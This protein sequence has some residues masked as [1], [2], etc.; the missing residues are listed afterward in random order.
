MFLDGQLR[1]LA[2]KKQRI[3]I[4]GD[5]GRRLLRLEYGLTKAA[6]LR[7]A[8]NLRLG[9]GLAERVLGFFRRR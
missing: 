7:S 6:A 9:F 3:A 1:L 4:R 5:L 8:S 2:A